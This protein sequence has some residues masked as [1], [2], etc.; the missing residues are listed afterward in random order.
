MIHLLT[1]FFNKDPL[2]HPEYEKRNKEYNETLINNLKSG[3]FEK[4][5]LF[6]EDNYSENILDTILNTYNCI[7]KVNKIIFNKQPT[8]K[9]FFLY[10]NENLKEKI[11]M[12]SNSDI[13]LNKINNSLIEYIKDQNTVFCLTRYENE[14]DKPLI[15]K[16]EGSHDSFIFKSPIHPDVI[17]NSDFV[18]NKLGSENLIIYLLYR[19]KY[20]LLNPCFQFKIIHNHNSNLRSY[21][22]SDRINNVEYM[23][24]Y[25]TL[26]VRP[27]LL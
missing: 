25:L 24:G 18:Q 20:Q 22:K 19:N 21:T 26:L 1:S 6:I 9:D 3:Y 10:G 23:P 2:L 12:I 14:I 17:K 8:Y 13:Y 27:C 5:H 16:F 15:D 4:I 11:I 7:D